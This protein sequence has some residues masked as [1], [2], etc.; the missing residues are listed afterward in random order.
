MKTIAQSCFT[1]VV[2]LIFCCNAIAQVPLP[3][4]VTA[5]PSM[6][7][8]SEYRL[9]NGLKV[10]LLEDR[11]QA[12]I[13][14]NITYLVGSRHEGYGEAGMAHLLEHLLFKGTPKHRDIKREF[15]SRGARWNGTTYFDRTNYFLTFDSTPANLEWALEL[16][17]D[18]MV[19][20]FISRAD[21]DSEM[22][23]VRNEFE[24]GENSAGRVLSQKVARAAYQ[25]HNYGRSVIGNRSDIENVPIER[26]QAFYASYYQPDN[27]VLV[28]AGDF[29]PATVLALVAR[30]FGAIPKP[31][32]KLPTTYTTE[33]AQDGEREVVLRRAGESP[34]LSLHYHAPPGTHADYAAFDILSMVL[35]DTPTGRLHKALVERGLAT[36]VSGGDRMLAERGALV[37][38]ATPPKPGT[39]QQP[40]RLR[41]GRDTCPAPKVDSLATLR[42]A[43]I[44]TVENLAANP[45]TEDEVTRAKTR[46]LTQ[47]DVTMTRT[48]QFAT[49]LSEWVA[50][51]DWRMFFRYRDYINAVSASAVNRAAQSH[52]IRSN[53]TVGVFLPEAQ[54]PRRAEIPAPPDLQLALRDYVG[55]P[56]IGGGEVFDS[57]PASIEART[58]RVA[59]SNGLKVAFLP[60]KSRGGMVTATLS[61]QY[62]TEESKFGRAQACAFAGAMLMRGTQARTREQIRNEITRLRANLSV[63]GGGG[64]VEVPIAGLQESLAL[65]SELLRRPRFD[66]AE[67]E[68]LR[69]SAIAGIESGRGDPGS[70]AS[71]RLSRHFNPYQRGHW[72][73]AAT[74]D[75]Q[76]EETRRV[77]LADARRCY[78]DFFGLSQAQMAIVGD[79]DPEQLLPHLERLFGD[80]KSP[81]PYA[82]IPVRAREAAPINENIITPDKANAT[83]RGAILLDVR[84]EDPDYPALVL[85]NHLFGGSI[86]ARL[87]TRIRE[88]DGLSYSVGS[89]LSVAAI[90]RYGQWSVSAIH[91]PQN[92]ARVETALME[93]IERVRQNGFTPEEVARGKEGY[94]QSRKLA[95][96][97]DSALASKLATD[98]YFARTYAWDAA[99]EQRVAT[100]TAAEITAAFVKHIDPRRLNLAKAGDFRQ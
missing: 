55:P 92:R 18:R 25:W 41:C 44:A 90:D 86:D 49:H 2:W 98:L 76:L 1:I 71:L 89:G 9:A 82:R 42:E 97:S 80:W 69:Q 56:G 6:G 7:G 72:S 39:G 88:K 70:R 60:K 16:E 57:A 45:V 99:F 23:V 75:E 17:A 65:M 38:S 46:L 34:F 54:A 74:I 73:Y 100:L 91:A 78:G 20:S 26:L 51:G 83:L 24:S 4:G 79:V 62:G 53:R 94:L 85:A 68:Q 64:S 81:A 48:H 96:A 22:T 40:A 3:A 11:S 47:M 15:T 21:L 10:L 59:L 33:A 52:L 66:A 87:A 32:R 30:H 84:D 5:G 27:A 67:F 36:S 14:T 61:F 63:G 12:L 29:D 19:N 28:V 8:I 50:L 77:E 37:F 43:F 31:A 13:T 35:G 58:R 93:E 95:R